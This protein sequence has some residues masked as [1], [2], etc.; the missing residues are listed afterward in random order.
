M[1][2]QRISGAAAALAD[3]ADPASNIAIPLIRP[4]ARNSHGRRAS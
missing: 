3:L 2:I 4:T 1:V